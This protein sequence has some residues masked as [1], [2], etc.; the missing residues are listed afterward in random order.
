MATFSTVAPVKVDN[1]LVGPG[2]PCFFIAELG[3]CHDGDIDLALELAE[4]A[5]AAGAHCVKTETFNKAAILGDPNVM[6]GYEQD[7]ERIEISL[8]K[9]M[10][11]C[12]LSL[13]EHAAVRA[14]CAKKGVAF[15]ATVHDFEA[16]DFLCEI[17]ASAIKIASPD[18]VHLPLLEY[19]ARSGLPVFMDTGACR[20]S[21]I[22]RAVETLRDAGAA[23]VV[24]NHN[25]AGHPAPAAGHALGSLKSMQGVLQTPMGL[26]CHYA[27]YEML[28][29]AVAAGADAL[30]KPVSLDRRQ[31]RPERAYSIS[32]GDIELVVATIKEIDQAM[33][34]LT[35]TFTTAQL[36]Y[37]QRNRMSCLASRDLAPGDLLDADTVWFARPEKGVSV[38]DFAKIKGRTVSR[39]IKK[40]AFLQWGDIE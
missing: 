2:H 17:K 28:Y 4:A 7:G 40:G 14:L 22:M 24:V 18:V 13:E 15:L 25:P 3:V 39:E 10:D 1:C 26:S 33:G 16:I 20:R 27:G 32:K 9:H 34:E 35:D 29:A 31:P 23:G 6:M 21:E 5:I 11:A 36:E 38:A 37:Q 19:A 8:A 30:E 12:E